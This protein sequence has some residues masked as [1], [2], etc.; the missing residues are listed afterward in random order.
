MRRPKFYYLIGLAGVDPSEAPKA[1]LWGKILEYPMLILAL[2]ILFL[3]HFQITG[4]VNIKYSVLI[5]RIVWGFFVFEFILLVTLVK[6]KPLYIL[7]NWLNLVVIVLGFPVIMGYVP[8]AAALRSA[9]LLVMLVLLTSLGESFREIL[10]RNQLGVTLL[11]G[12]LLVFIAG[13]LIS[14]IDPAVKTPWEG[15]WWAWVTVT[16]VG[17]GDIV[18]VSVSGRVLGCILILMGI[19]LFSLLT[20]SFSV[21]FISQQEKTLL[22]KERRALYDINHL[23]EQIDRLEAKTERIL[24][25]LDKQ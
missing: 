19:G 7:T 6:D 20:A 14:G 5:D 10:S 11:I 25:K 12:M 18:P 4:Y 13:V 8:Y 24:N 9:R 17:Y 16:T 3:W 22:D 1:K 2:S 23:K 15:I 21:F